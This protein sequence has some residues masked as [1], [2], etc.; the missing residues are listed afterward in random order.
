M[1]AAHERPLQRCA[2]GGV[3]RICCRH[4]A[5]ERSHALT[6]TSAYVVPLMLVRLVM[7]LPVELSASK[8]ALMRWSATKAGGTPSRLGCASGAMTGSAQLVGLSTAITTAAHATSF[9]EWAFGHARSAGLRSVSYRLWFIWIRLSYWPLYNSCPHCAC[10]LVCFNF[11]P[12]VFCVC[13]LINQH[14]YQP[15]GCSRGQ[16]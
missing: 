7:C 2:R 14:K 9:V 16:G 15:I 12:P 4:G 11:A 6:S 5:A 8:R 1:V 3:L 13:F 10:R